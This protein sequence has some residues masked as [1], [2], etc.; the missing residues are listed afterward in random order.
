MISF[1]RHY[2][3]R[4]TNTSFQFQF[5]CDRYT[6][7]GVF[8]YHSCSNV[9]TSVVRPNPIGTAGNLLDAASWLLGRGYGV[10]RAGRLVNEVYK[11]HAWQ[12][13]YEEAIEEAKSFFS[14]CA[15]CSARVCRDRCWNTEA[16][17]CTSCAPDLQCEAAAAI[18]QAAKDQIKTRASNTDQIGD[19]DLTHRQ[20]AICPHCHQRHHGGK[21]CSSCGKEILRVQFCSTCGHKLA[22]V[23]GMRFCSHCGGN[24]G[25]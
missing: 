22:P 24:L 7:V 25:T 6:R 4:S 16:Q 19:L 2:V 9:Y 12:E 15:R 3:D 23:E 14:Q 18:A 20:T 17:L 5:H 11:P 21:F 1:T 10:G 13:A 8:P